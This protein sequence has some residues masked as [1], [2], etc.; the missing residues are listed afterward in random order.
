MKSMHLARRVLFCMC[1]AFEK[2]V[3]VVLPQ[4]I[5][6]MQVIFSGYGWLWYGRDYVIGICTELLSISVKLWILDM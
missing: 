6:A 2:C 1:N 3:H 4:L 5:I